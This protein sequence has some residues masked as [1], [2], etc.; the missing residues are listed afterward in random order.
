MSG[1]TAQAE[2]AVVSRGIIVVAEDDAAT[3]MLLCRILSR[4]EFSVVAVENGELACAEIRR[5]CPDVVL[6]DWMMPV[7]NGPRAVEILKADPATCTIPI[8]MLT[9]HS[10]IED[11]VFALEAG[12]ADFITKPFNA[13]ELVARI[14]QQ[15][16]WR[17]TLSNRTPAAC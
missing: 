16:R 9:T 11:R 7:M 10:R 6:L 17:E 8:L 4:A 1:V 3:R 14:E 2:P 15:L 5:H 12:V 13:R